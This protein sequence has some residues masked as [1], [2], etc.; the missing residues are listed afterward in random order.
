[1]AK[2]VKLPV[3]YNFSER[4]Y[5]NLLWHERVY[6]KNEFREW[7]KIMRLLRWLFAPSKSKKDRNRYSRPF[8]VSSRQQFC[9]TKLTGYKRDKG[10]H[11]RFLNEYLPQYNKDDV[12]KKPELFSAGNAGEAFLKDYTDH[13]DDL[14]FKFIISP[15]SPRVDT[16]ALVKT[17]MKRMEAATGYQFRWLSAVHTNTNHPH[18]HILIN[19]KDRAG[20]EVHF[21]KIMI[22]QTMREM[23]GQICTEMIGERTAEQIRLTRDKIYQSSRFCILDMKIETQETAI[24]NPSKQ[25]H[26]EVF[27]GNAELLRR[28]MH[29]EEMGLA[30]KETKTHYLLEKDWKDKLRAIGRYNAFLDARRDLQGVSPC[31]LNLYTKESGI[32]SGVVTKVIRKDDEAS[33]GNALIIENRDLNKA[34]Y[35]PLYYEPDKTKLLNKTV[36][37]EV[38]KDQKGKLTPNIKVETGMGK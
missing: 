12:E 33:W 29:L 24:P 14:H 16:K 17:L 38:K 25:Y 26:S 9:V 20:K 3:L 5:D 36:Q 4:R 21:D 34:W 32:A 6:K 2:R 28:L 11:L 1:M 22:M 23:C 13:L 30:K 10:K 35:V 31:E 27:T 37:C 7:N 19:G 8:N 18:A 15:E